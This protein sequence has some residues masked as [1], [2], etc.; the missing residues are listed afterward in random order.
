MTKQLIMTR[1]YNL[2]TT[3][4]CLITQYHIAKNLIIN[5]ILTDDKLIIIRKFKT[6]IIFPNVLKFPLV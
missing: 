2:I 5:T 4:H 1:I 3:N 6:S